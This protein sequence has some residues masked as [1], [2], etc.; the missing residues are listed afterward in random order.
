MREIIFRGYNKETKQWYYGLLEKLKGI[1]YER[2]VYYVD[3]GDR[4]SPF[5][6]EDSIGQ[7]TGF[8]DK[9]GEKI[10]EGD[11][12][13][14]DIDFYGYIEY[15]EDRFRIVPEALDMTDYK[16]KDI[17]PICKVVNNRYEDTRYTKG[18]KR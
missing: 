14:W 11:V 5:V 13:N 8:N 6:E 15:W 3:D 9:N 1:K 12:I 16:L 18:I 10:F 17:S 4:P 7:Y 2:D